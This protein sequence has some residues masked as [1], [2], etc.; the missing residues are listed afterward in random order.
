MSILVSSPTTPRVAVVSDYTLA[1]LG[2]AETAFTQQAGALAAVTD[3]LAICPDSAALSALA[4]HP[5]ITAVPVPVAFTVPA[6]GFPV[7]RHTPQLRGVIRAAF[8]RAGTDV[9]HVHSEF[10]IAA[11][12]IAA[13]RELGIPVVHTVHT[14]FWQAGVAMQPLLAMGAP[15]FHHAVTGLPHPARRL[16]ERRGDSALRNI[17]LAT[18]LAADRVISPS[19]HQAQRLRAA[20]LTHVD[21]VP[22]SVAGN[23]AAQPVTRI[24][25]PLRVLWSGRFAPEKRILPFLRAASTAIER[26]GPERLQ[27]DVL[28]AGVQFAAAER[29]VAQR[30][31]PRLHGRVPNA[32]VPAWLARSHMSALTS[33]GWDNQPMTVAESLMALRGVL[34]CDPALT[35][36]LTLAGIPALRASEEELAARLVQ[37]ALDPAPVIAASAA[38]VQARQLFS[39]EEFTRSVV[40]SY[41]R[42]GVPDLVLTS[43]RR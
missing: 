33:V 30:P 18:G 27:V 9:V 42:A 28:G 1:T 24:D 25:G 13:A 3:V 36:G 8:A 26:V 14:F 16:A 4:T 29:L 7:A 31:G 12:A 19:A 37:L 32:D 10:G 22:N 2:G 40:Q 20:G 35:E 5:R 6:L 34:W 38:A 39:A 15:A 21:V 11:A 43:G 41:H 17:T 23:P